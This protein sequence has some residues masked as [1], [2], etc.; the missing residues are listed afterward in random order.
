MDV[1]QLQ[2]RISVLYLSSRVVAIDVASFQSIYFDIMCRS[3]DNNTS[4][5]THHTWL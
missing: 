1:D 4:T 2:S 5:H 3:L